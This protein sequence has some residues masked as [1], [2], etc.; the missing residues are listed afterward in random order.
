MILQQCT[1]NRQ[2]FNT[3]VKIEQSLTIAKSIDQSPLIC[4]E[5]KKLNVIPNIIRIIEFF[6]AVT[7][8]EME[9]FQ[10]QI[11]AGDLYEKF[12]TDTID[13]IILMFKMARQ[14]DF[15]KIYRCDSL[16]IMEWANKYLDVKSATREKMLRKSTDC[17]V[18]RNDGGKFFHE[19]P[20]EFQKKFDSIGKAKAEP[21]LLPSKATEALTEEKHRRNIQKLIDNEKT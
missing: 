8:K 15:G 16:E 3:L 21:T 2:A 4:A 13:D 20:E 6:L 18:P 9:S 11:L 17:F 5:G 1:E 19:L 14:A 10:I 7:G 12:K